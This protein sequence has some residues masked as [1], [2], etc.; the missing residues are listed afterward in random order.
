M[1]CEQRQGRLR[2][3]GQVAPRDSAFWR[4]RSARRAATTVADPLQ[5]VRVRQRDRAQRLGRQLEHLA[6]ADGL[7]RRRP[8]LAG[9]HRHL[10]EVAAGIEDAPAR[11]PTPRPRARG[12]RTMTN[13][14]LP[15]SSCRT[16]VSPRPKSCSFAR[17]ASSV[18]SSCVSG[19]NRSTGAS[20]RFEPLEPIRRR[21]RRPSP[22]WYSTWMRVRDLVPVPPQ[23][24][25][26][27]GPHLIQRRRVL[28]EVGD[29][30]PDEV[31]D[32]RG[33]RTRR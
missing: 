13:I 17:A 11:G 21:A 3:F 1:R 7:H 15:A 2:R 26:D 12:P 29:P 25:V 14:E 33:R 31:V 22:C 28:A 19:A 10:A 27:R 20:T 4:S 6:V 32:R 9:Q 24:V 23:R 16:M 18:R 8:R 30:E 5:H